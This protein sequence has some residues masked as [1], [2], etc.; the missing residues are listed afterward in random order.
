MAEAAAV[1]ASGWSEIA[2]VP[3]GILPGA[4]IPEAGPLAAGLPG[5]GV[6]PEGTEATFLPEWHSVP[7]LLALPPTA[8]RRVLADLAEGRAPA[9]LPPAPASELAS[10]GVF[11]LLGVVADWRPE[12]VADEPGEV[13][14]ADAAAFEAWHAS[15]L[16]AGMGVASM[17]PPMPPSE[18]GE[19]FER[20]GGGALDD[21]RL[22]ELRGFVEMARGEAPGDDV[23][24]RLRETDGRFELTLATRSG[25]VL[26]R[27]EMGRD[28]LPV[29]PDA[30]PGAVGAIVPLVAELPG[31]VRPPAVAQPIRRPPR[32]SGGKPR[33]RLV[34]GRRG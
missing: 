2:V 12:P 1:G 11:A 33:L 19:E 23:V 10:G 32:P 25:R 3:A 17:L 5:C 28:E 15:V 18:L 31:A 27:R 34:S 24:C 29:P 22:E 20:A 14:P 26:D 4:P 8:V 6:F 16:A 13:F 21:A 7:Q 9:D 30:F